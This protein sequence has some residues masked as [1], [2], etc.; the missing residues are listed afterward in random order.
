MRHHLATAASGII[1]LVAFSTAWAWSQAVVLTIGAMCAAI[2]AI[3]AAAT[4]AAAAAA[5]A[6]IA[7]AIAAE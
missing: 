5:I 2:V 6:A 4:A 3:V 1:S 7:A